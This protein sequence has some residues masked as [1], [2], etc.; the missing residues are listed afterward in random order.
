[1]PTYSYFCTKCKESFELFFYIKDYIEQPPCPT[2]KCKQTNRRYIE[3]VAT[4]NASVKKA[5]S[6][7]K[8]LG[9]LANR[10][11]DR[12]SDDQKQALHKKHNKY[13]DD[14]LLKDLPK[15]MS[16]MKKQPKTQWTENGKTTANR[17]RT[18]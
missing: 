8:T 1:M 15:G 12:M 18:R 6:E 2:C 11:R 3:D 17:R 5:D 4:L 13:R 14:Q 10:N 16:R 7:L 9:D